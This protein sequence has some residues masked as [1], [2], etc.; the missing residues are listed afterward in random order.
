MPFPTYNAL[1]LGFSYVSPQTPPRAHR[2]HSRNLG[3]S[4]AVVKNLENNAQMKPK[5]E[6]EVEGEGVVLRNVWVSKDVDSC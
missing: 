4:P 5:L 2:T 1:G 3:K 6:R